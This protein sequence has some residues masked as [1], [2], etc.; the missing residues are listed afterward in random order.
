MRHQKTV[1][2]YQIAATHTEFVGL[3]IPGGWEE[4]FR[5]IGEPYTGPLF[6][7][8][9][10]R[11]PFQVLI[12]KLIAATEKFDMIPVREKQSFDPQPWD[13][14]EVSLPGK[15]EEGGY[16]LRD[17]AG[18]K[19]SV[20]GLV[21]RGMATRK[22]TN[23]RFSIYEIAGSGLSAGFDQALKFAKTHHAL[24]T[25]EGILKVTIDGKST[26]ASFGETVF[27]PAGTSFK[28]EIESKFAKA[29]LFA[30][31]GGLGEVLSSIGSAYTLPGVPNEQEAKSADTSALKGLEGELE[32]TS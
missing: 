30:N 20:G 28:V 2:Q 3:I 25:V 10:N 31:G 21:V 23:D 14:S 27:I 18:E 22:E 5:F 26:L 32:F 7:T 16:F 12:P 19:K 6:P 1:H 24:Q 13:G 4:F 11:N 17:G 15:C 8:N 29:Y 9:D